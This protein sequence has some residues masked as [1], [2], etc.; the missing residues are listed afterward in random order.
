[1]L[2]SA[3]THTSSRFADDHCNVIFSFLLFEDLVDWFDSSC[4]GYLVVENGSDRLTSKAAN[5]I[6]ST[7]ILPRML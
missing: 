4:R 1:M 2:P 7:P 3:M 6:D 5:S